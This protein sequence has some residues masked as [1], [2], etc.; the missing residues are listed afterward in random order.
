MRKVIPLLVALLG[1]VLFA[2]GVGNA[3]GGV[4]QTI[5]SVGAPWVADGPHTQRLDEGGYVLYEQATTRTLDPQDVTI[6]GPDGAVPIGGTATTTVTLGNTTWVGVAGF[7]ATVAGEYTITV[8][9]EGP[10]LA[11]GPS[12]AGTLGNAFGWVGAAVLGGFIALAGLGWF[13]AVLFIGGKKT[14]AVGAAGAAGGWYPDPQDPSQLRW[15][16]GRSWTEQR[17]PR[18]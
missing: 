17:T 9:R 1:I 6:T 13:V 16:D 8:D 15:W 12:L 7:T 11:V 5:N 4:A 10:E 14:P 2:V 3:V 18:Q